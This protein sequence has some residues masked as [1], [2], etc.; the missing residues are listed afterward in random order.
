[1]KATH[2]YAAD[3]SDEMSFEAG[4]FISVI[5]FEDPDEQVILHYIDIIIK[6]FA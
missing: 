5:P 6:K 1:M 2:R 3:D 4:E